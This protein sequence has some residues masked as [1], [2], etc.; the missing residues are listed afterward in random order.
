M[1]SCAF[2]IVINSKRGGALKEYQSF[3]SIVYK[4]WAMLIHEN[5]KEL[6]LRHWVEYH[7]NTSMENNYGD[8]LRGVSVS[9]FVCAGSLYTGDELEKCLIALYLCF[10]PI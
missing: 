5:M 8:Y 9:I 4:C 7:Y 10:S 1:S 3:C 2:T 6:S